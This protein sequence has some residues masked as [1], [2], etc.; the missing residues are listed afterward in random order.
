M[1]SG[2]ETRVRQH[3]PTVACIYCRPSD[4]ALHEIVGSCGGMYARLDDFPT[5]AGHLQIVPYRHVESF[6]DMTDREARD[7]HSLARRM[8]R[9]LL[10]RFHADGFTL[11]VDDGAAAGRSVPHLHVHII[12]RRHG[13]VDDPRGGI[14]RILPGDPNDWLN[15][16]RPKGRS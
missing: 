11:G 14:R 12:P 1:S 15:P 16:S 8:K 6:F 4:E 3:R 13:D 5:T 10:E 9:W 7:F 2:I